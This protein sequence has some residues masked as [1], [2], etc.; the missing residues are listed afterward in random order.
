[1]LEPG[2]A[3]VRKEA[4]KA[5]GPSFFNKLNAND[6][7][8]A[9]SGLETSKVYIDKSQSQSATSAMAGY[10]INIQVAPDASLTTIERNIDKIAKGVRQ[11]FEE[12]L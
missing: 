12:Y 1:M 3:V 7:E 11:V 6:L 4:V 9:F 2:E 10:N 8:N 5:R